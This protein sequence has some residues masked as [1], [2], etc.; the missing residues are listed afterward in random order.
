MINYECL[1]CFELYLL[2]CQK[3]GKLSE[4]DKILYDVIQELKLKIERE[5]QW[6]ELTS[7]VF[8]DKK[9]NNA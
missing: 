1:E 4:V 6:T 2:K 5:K 7:D 3:C 8:C 9:A